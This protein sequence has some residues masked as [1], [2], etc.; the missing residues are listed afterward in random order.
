M[1]S[2]RAFGARDRYESR[3]HP[4]RVQECAPAYGIGSFRLT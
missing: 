3:G 2:R 1:S 4:R